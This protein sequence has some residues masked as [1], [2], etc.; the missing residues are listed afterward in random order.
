MGWTSL[1][2]SRGIFLQQGS[3]LGFLY[4]YPG[5]GYSRIYEKMGF[6]HEGILKDAIKDGN[7][8]ADDILMAILEDE[9]RNMHS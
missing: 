6:K 8:F 5:R 1:D 4:V 3:C 2:Y 9:W 7:D